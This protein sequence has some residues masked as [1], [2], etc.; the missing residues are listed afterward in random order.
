MTPIRPQCVA[1]TAAGDQG[2]RRYLD[3]NDAVGIPCDDLATG[4]D[5]DRPEDLPERFLR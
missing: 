2:A 5:V 3:D 1:A 4:R